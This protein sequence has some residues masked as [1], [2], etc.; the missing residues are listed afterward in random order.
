MKAIKLFCLISAV[1]IFVISVLF[2]GWWAMKDHFVFGDGRFDQVRWITARATDEAPCYRGD[3]AQDLKQRVL[4]RG[5][6]RQSATILLGRPTWED[7]G[8]IEYELGTCL[9]REYG[10]RL[11]FDENDRLIR[12]RIVQH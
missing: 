12:S 9:W 3:M 1:L 8:Q 4:L 6:P 11:Y 7:H 5:M 10:L 2:F